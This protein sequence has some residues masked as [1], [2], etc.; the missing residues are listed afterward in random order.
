MKLDQGFA[1]IKSD[2]T[3]PGFVKSETGMEPQQITFKEG[4]R[5][6]ALVEQEKMEPY[7]VTTSI[8]MDDIRVRVSGNA[9][10]NDS[11]I[12]IAR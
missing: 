6:F 7:R 12:S 2:V 3:V 8:R 10:Q 4:D 11:Q 5:V 1:T 9:F